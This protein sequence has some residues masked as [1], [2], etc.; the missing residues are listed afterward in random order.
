MLLCVV[1][2]WLFAIPLWCDEV[3][4]GGSI[5]Q[6]T[7]AG[8]QESTL[9]DLYRLMGEKEHYMEEKELRI[10]GI[11]M[12]LATPLISDEQRYDIN[13]QLFNEYKTY[14]SDSA[15]HYA[16]ENIAIGERLLQPDKLFGSML[17]LSSLYIIS[18]MFI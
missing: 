17:Y 2:L 13:L 10:D 1:M 3:G 9:Q 4:E 14:I 12:L 16:S 5:L 18:G 11:K 7:V 8:E 6:S 15:I